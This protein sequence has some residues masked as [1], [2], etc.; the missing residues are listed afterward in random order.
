MGTFFPSAITFEP[1]V[2]RKTCVPLMLDMTNHGLTLPKYSI[3]TGD[4]L[5]QQAKAQLQ[6]WVEALEQGIEVIPVWNK[7]N[8]EHTI[9]GSEPNSVRDTAD[10][11]HGWKLPHFCDAGHMTLETASRFFGPCDFYMIV[12][13]DAIGHPAAGGDDRDRS[14][15]EEPLRVARGHPAWRCN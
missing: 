2:R 5:A 6:A 10:A 3:G 4:R 7:S 14:L 15:C 11:A 8:R 12:F 1:C 13:A 9:I